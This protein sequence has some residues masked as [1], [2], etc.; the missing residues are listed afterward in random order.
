[1][2]RYQHHI[3]WGDGVVEA[4]ITKEPESGRRGRGSKTIRVND[5]CKGID[6]QSPSM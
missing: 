4:G 6:V 3:L 2:N 5:I 1:M